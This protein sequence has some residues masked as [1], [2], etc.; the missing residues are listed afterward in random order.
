MLAIAMVLPSSAA[1]QGRL[2]PASRAPVAARP[3]SRPSGATSKRSCPSRS[4]TPRAR[5]PRCGM[6]LVLRRRHHPAPRRRPPGMIVGKQKINV[7][8]PQRQ[9]PLRIGPRDVRQVKVHGVRADELP[10]TEL[11]GTLVI[12][13]SQAQ[14]GLPRDDPVDALPARE[15][16][17]GMAR[18]KDQAGHRHRAGLPLV[19]AAPCA[20]RADHQRRGCRRR[21]HRSS[22]GNLADRAGGVGHRRARLGDGQGRRGQDPRAARRREAGHPAR[23]VHGVGVA[24]PG[25]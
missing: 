7:W 20:Q 16:A 21:G 15:E 10:E 4:A 25:R 1:A 14:T 12:V 3:S 9:K 23:C 11:A 13:H 8:L 18:G 24:R 2:S 5:P 17:V 6:R 22:R 19:A